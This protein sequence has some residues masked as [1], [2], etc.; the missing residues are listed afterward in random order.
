M[1]PQTRPL[2]LPWIEL[3]RSGADMKRLLWWRWMVEFHDPEWDVASAT[4]QGI[5][6]CLNS[7]M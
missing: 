1:T 6:R 2:S 5:D 7:A 4:K 3:L